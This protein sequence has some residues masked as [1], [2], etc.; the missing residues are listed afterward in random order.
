M[1]VILKPSVDR[2]VVALPGPDAQPS[3][4]PIWIRIKNFWTR[5]TTW[6]YLPFEWVYLPIFVYWLWLSLKA[7]SFF[8]FS[9]S[10]P[11]IETGGMLG[12]S[13]SDILEKIDD[14]YKPKTLFFQPD[15]SLPDL[16]MQ[17]AIHTLDFP[18]IAKP[19]V[20]ERGW[21]VEK[22]DSEAQ[23]A[24]YLQKIRIPFIVQEYVDFSIELGVFYYRFPSQ[25]HGTISSI[26]V[27]EFLSI[28]G[29]GVHTVG[30]QVAANPRARLQ[31][32]TL[33]A[34]YASIWEEV[35]PVGK[36]QVLVFIGNH[37]K[38]T[39][40]LNGNHLITH[41]LTQVF[42]RMS[43]T[44]DGFYFGRFDLR[45][46]SL[47]EL[48]VGEGIRVVELNGAGAEPGHIY[49]PTVSVWEAYR[50]IFHHWNV[51]YAISRENHQ[52]GVPYLTFKEAHTIWK[53][54]KAKRVWQEG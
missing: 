18:I 7:R 36:K 10:N 49:D 28:E 53:T 21:M 40:F 26:V 42:D 8:F 35:W 27:K 15:T 17:L 11:G 25:T 52:K 6:E 2:P 9:A 48:Y 3:P 4:M 24:S 33:A 31:Y 14:A 30:E 12:E 46:R 1:N 34:R 44:I 5:W 43:R 45:C 22:I 47:D 51:C 13:K 32:Q 19:D 39:K 50:A 37:C 38:G 23:L 29:D 20:G 41:Q 16:Q 54:T